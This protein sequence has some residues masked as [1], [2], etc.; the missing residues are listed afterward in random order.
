MKIAIN[1][2]Y[3]GF[4]ISKEVAD[5]LIKKGYSLGPG[6]F[7]KGK[8]FHINNETF[9]I[10]DDDYD[11]YRTHPDLI[12]AIETS[13]NPNG[14]YANIEIVDIPDDIEWEID[15]YD[16]VETIHEKHRSW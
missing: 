13:S 10:K 14:S 16:G 6:D 9:N 15:D 1:K 3:G 5:K 12:E 11:K 7:S 4:S 2:C 8:S